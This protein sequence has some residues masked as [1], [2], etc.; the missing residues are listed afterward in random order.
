MTN[1][2]FLNLFF[3]IYKKKKQLLNGLIRN[4][5]LPIAAAFLTVGFDQTLWYIDILGFLLTK[6]FPIG[7]AKYI[8][9]PETTKLKLL[10]STHHIWFLPLVV[11]MCC[12]S[13][14][15]YPKEIYYFAYLI[16]LHM[17]AIPRLTTPKTLNIP[18]T[19]EEVY[20]NIM[21]TYELWKDVKNGLFSAFDRS[22]PAIT[23]IFSN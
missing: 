11:A 23:T 7:V 19:K 21:C 14:K 9:W 15:K 12:K 1:K 6:K 3:F 16:S 13:M 22:H 20:M 17:T 18:E 10:T 8:T 5:T 2:F 4:K